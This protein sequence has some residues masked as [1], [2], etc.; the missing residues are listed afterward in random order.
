[1][2]VY[3][4]GGMIKESQAASLRDIWKRQAG[5]LAAVKLFEGQGMGPAWS[6]Y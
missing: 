5:E 4:T 6:A 1:M 3:A 2:V